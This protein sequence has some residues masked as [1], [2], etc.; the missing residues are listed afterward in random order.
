[1]HEPTKG[2]HERWSAKTQFLTRFH[3]RF[4]AVASG[5]SDL[6]AA[7]DSVIVLRRHGA[8]ALSFQHTGVLVLEGL[9]RLEFGPV[10]CGLAEKGGKTGCATG[11]TRPVRVQYKNNVM[12]VLTRCGQRVCNTRKVVSKHRTIGFKI[13]LEQSSEG[14][15]PSFG[16]LYE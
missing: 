1:M 9:I 13:Q 15:S 14:S 6:I 7:S 8:D 10:W 12:A 4:G 3:R 5:V 2:V 16:T 11:N